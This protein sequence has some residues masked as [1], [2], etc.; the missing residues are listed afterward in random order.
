MYIHTYHMYIYTEAGRDL[1]AGL[2]RRH[3][4]H[5]ADPPAGPELG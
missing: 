1:G 4:R 5:T 3:Q 2:I